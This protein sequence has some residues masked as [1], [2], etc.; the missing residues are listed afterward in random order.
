MSFWF[1]M[2]ETIRQ[3]L[4]HPPK[5]ILLHTPMKLSWTQD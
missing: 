3:S 5:L 4:G 1:S 2:T